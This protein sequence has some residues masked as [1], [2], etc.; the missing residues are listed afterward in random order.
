MGEEV[1][2]GKSI[3]LEGHKELMDLDNNSS[4]VE[5]SVSQAIIS[6]SHTPLGLCKPEIQR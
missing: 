4:K 2:H 1:L 3:G 6:I 5:R